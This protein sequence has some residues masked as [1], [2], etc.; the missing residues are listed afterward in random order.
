MSGGLVQ[1]P[2]GWH[3]RRS[4][5]SPSCKCPFLVL[6]IMYCAALSTADTIESHL[7]HQLWIQQTTALEFAQ[8]CLLR[9]RRTYAAASVCAVLL[10]REAPQAAAAL[11]P[12]QTVETLASY[13]NK[14]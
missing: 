4:R 5:A 2:H 9:R 12:L 11:T 7:Q 13:E 6:A 10:P 3:E 8:L 14:Q 1:V